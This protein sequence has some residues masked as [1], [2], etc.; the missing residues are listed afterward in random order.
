MRSDNPA[1][2]YSNPSLQFGAGH[3]PQAKSRAGL[4]PNWLK[5]AP[6]ILLHLALLTVFLLCA[7]SFLAYSVT[8]QGDGPK[9]A[10]DM[11]ANIN[12]GGGKV[13]WAC[14]SA[15]TKNCQININGWCCTSSKENS[16]CKNCA[17]LDEDDD[18]DDDDDD[19][20]DDD[21]V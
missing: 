19:D 2:T 5:A 21:E 7:A 10:C 3:P 16:K 11:C 8:A 4:L 12:T 14:P 17:T 6:F 1:N 18:G 13:K 15:T 20:D 9:G